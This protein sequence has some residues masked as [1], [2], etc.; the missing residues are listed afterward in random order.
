MQNL[1]FTYNRIHSFLARRNKS[2]NNKAAAGEMRLEIYLYL[3]FILDS[4]FKNAFSE[5]HCQL[6]GS[7]FYISFICSNL[8]I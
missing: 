5:L 6:V 4:D 1:C 7:F 3:V 8:F 2:V